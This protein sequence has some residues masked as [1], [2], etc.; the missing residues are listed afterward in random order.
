MGLILFF[1]ENFV[2]SVEDFKSLF[3]G[4]RKEK[5]GAIKTVVSV[6]IVYFPQIICAI[7]SII[8]GSF[9]ILKSIVNLS[10]SETASKLVSILIFNNQI[11]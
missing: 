10:H 2:S 1:S 3:Q 11:F 8:S 5:R 9:L 7:L 6:F 4:K